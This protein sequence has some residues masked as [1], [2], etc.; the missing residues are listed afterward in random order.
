MVANHELQRAEEWSGLRG[1]TNLLYKENRA[2]WGTRRWWINALLWTGMLGGL[3]AMVVFMLPTIAQATDD[4]A[5]AKAGGPIP[6]GLEMGRTVFFELG[7]MALAIGVIILCQDLIVDEKQTGLTEWLLAKPVT[8]RA[9]V[10]AKLV[11][12]ALAVMILLVALPSLACYLLL[13]ARVGSF[14]PFLPFLGGVGIMIVHTLFYLTLTLMLGTLF[15]SRPPILGIALGVLLGGNLLA[16]FLKPLLSVTPLLLGKVASL[17]AGS[18]PL[19]PELLLYPVI[20]SVLWSV[21][22][23]VVAVVRFEKTEF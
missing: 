13:S 21:I 9:Y 18:Q 20:A 16:G 10:L 3:A 4:P 22:F 6:F 11:A 19:P 8:R 5:V 1:F 7:A 14:F 15:N 23:I 12:S 2:W 17:T